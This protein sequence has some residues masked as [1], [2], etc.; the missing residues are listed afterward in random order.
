MLDS[1]V[2]LDF[3][4]HNRLRDEAVGLDALLRFLKEHTIIAEASW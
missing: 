4:C 1:G 2:K 3:E